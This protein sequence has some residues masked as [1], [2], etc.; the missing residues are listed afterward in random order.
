MATLQKLGHEVAS[1]YH[2]R[3]TPADRARLAGGRLARLAGRQA[4]DW[5]ALARQHLTERLADFRPDLLISIQGKLDPPTAQL[6]KQRFPDLKMVF[7]WGDV[8]TAQGQQKIEQAAM[9]ADRI[10]VSF[11]GIHEILAAREGRQ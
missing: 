4:P 2:N 10:L 8:L 5:P 3:K 9:F 7:W 6:L 1:Y 11:R